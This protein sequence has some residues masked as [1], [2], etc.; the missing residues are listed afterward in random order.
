MKVK[1]GQDRGGEDSFSTFK[2]IAESSETSR[3]AKEM[4]HFVFIRNLPS[5]YHLR[6][7]ICGLG[8]RRGVFVCLADLVIAVKFLFIFAQHDNNQPGDLTVVVD[9]T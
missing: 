9:R 4:F 1:K 6:I 7:E 5:T 2:R 3:N 8:A